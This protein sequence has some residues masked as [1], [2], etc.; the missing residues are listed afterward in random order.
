MQLH[1]SPHHLVR[2]VP[3]ERTGFAL[4][5]CE[6]SQLHAEPGIELICNRKGR[7]VR[8]K[9]RQSN[10]IYHSSAGNAYLQQLNTGHVW[11]LTGTPGAK[12]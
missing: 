11:S 9:Q 10:S 1:S 4:A 6:E 2:A 5:W 7:V 12:R 8:A 3:V